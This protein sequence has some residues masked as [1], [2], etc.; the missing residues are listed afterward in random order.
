MHIKHRQ[1]FYG[2]VWN[3]D[4]Y[5]KISKI[6]TSRQ[7]FATFVVHGKELSHNF[8]VNGM[9]PLRSKEKQF[10]QNR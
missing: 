3:T 10:L 7:E 8:Y 6:H 5:R 2:N 4:E 1:R 9:L